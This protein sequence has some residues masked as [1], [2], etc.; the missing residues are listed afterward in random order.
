MPT[1]MRFGEFIFAIAQ[2]YHLILM[3]LSLL[4][5]PPPASK[6]AAKKAVKKAANAAKS[7]LMSKM[8]GAFRGPSDPSP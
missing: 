7:K 6:D 4:A 5:F 2:F 1:F 3:M 8:K